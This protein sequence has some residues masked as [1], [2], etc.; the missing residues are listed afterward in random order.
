M[1]LLGIKRATEWGYSLYEFWIFDSADA[2]L[3]EI[4]TSQE[5]VDKPDLRPDLVITDIT[6]SPES[7]SPATDVTLHAVVENQ[8]RAA[9]LGDFQVS[10][11]IGEVVIGKGYNE[12][13]LAPGA[14]V[15]IEGQQT[16]TPEDTG[17]FIMFAQVDADTSTPTG[18]VEEVDENN[19][20]QS[21]YGI[22]KT[23]TALDLEATK[24]AVLPTEASPTAKPDTPT[25]EP[26]AGE[27]LIKPSPDYR[28]IWIVVVVIVICSAAIVIYCL[29][30]R[31]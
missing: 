25:P 21:I 6:W 24:T 2:P 8:G 14:S 15:V 31:K 12:K 13:P 17:V 7:I 11:T 16:W 28:W 9:V 29:Q 1:R 30:K 5:V 18:A 23:E 20:L 26:T 10:F 4:S 27:Y 3:P 22:V 19:N